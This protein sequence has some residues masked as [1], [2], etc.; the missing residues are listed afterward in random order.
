MDT[1]LLFPGFG[2]SHLFAALFFYIYFAYSLQVIATKTQTVNVWM[3]WIP[4]LNLLLMV[5][6][7]RLSGIALIP[8]FIP[9]INIIYAAYIW[10][11]IAYAVNKSRWLGLV[12]LVPILNLGLPGYLAF[13]EY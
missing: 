11:E 12:I 8:F 4:I 5:R 6:I 2:I 1:G 13:F 7:C 3:A 9:F 10:G